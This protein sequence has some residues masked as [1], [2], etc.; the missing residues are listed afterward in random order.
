LATTSTSNPLPGMNSSSQHKQPNH[1]MRARDRHPGIDKL[2]TAEDSHTT[3]HKKTSVPSEI[4]EI[5]KPNP[6]V[7]SRS[8]GH[9]VAVT[10]L[11]RGIHPKYPGPPFTYSTIIGPLLYRP[12]QLTP[13]DL[14]SYAVHFIA[15]QMLLPLGLPT[16]S[17]RHHI[18]RLRPTSQLLGLH[19]LIP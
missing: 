1:D 11:T 5:S 2:T 15:C 17:S 10:H 18:H 3:S 19:L 14:F 8:Q 12:L 6:S 4:D 7:Q 16:V 13:Q 9:G